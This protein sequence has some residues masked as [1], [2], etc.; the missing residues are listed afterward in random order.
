MR[1]W[2][3]GPLPLRS[4]A[5]APQQILKQLLTPLAHF[6]SAT[7]VYF[8]SALDRVALTLSRA[9]CRAWV[10][11]SSV[12]ASQTQ[13]TAALATSFTIVKERAHKWN[14]FRLK[15]GT[16]VGWGGSASSSHG[17]EMNLDFTVN[18]DSR[19]KAM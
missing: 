4:R 17:K 1:C 14:S 6:Y 16:V 9:V 10:A 13:C 18:S 11:V 2:G 3:A 8:Y 7:V 12:L 15:S 19:L 5:P